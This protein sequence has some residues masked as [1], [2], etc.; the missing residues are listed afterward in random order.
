MM[1]AYLAPDA[2]M[3]LTSVLAGIVGFVLM[4]WQRLVFYARRIGRWC[5]RLVGMGGPSAP[6]EPPVDPPAEPPAGDA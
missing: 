5:A 2:I 1:L 4:T 6:A 3:P